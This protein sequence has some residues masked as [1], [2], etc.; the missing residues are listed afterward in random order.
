MKSGIRRLLKSAAAAATTFL[1]VTNW[2][3]QKGFADPVPGGTLDPLTVPKYQTPLVIPPAMPR[4]DTIRQDR[5]DVDYYEIAVRQFQQQVLP[6]GMPKTTVWGYGNAA[7]RLPGP[8]VRTSFNYPG[9]TIEA[10]VD[11][12]VRV[13]WINKL[14]DSRNNYLA[15]LLPLDQTLMW[16]NP[17]GGLEE[18]DMN[19]TDPTPYTGPVPIVTHLHGAHSPQESDGFP[20][21][22]FL[23][24]AKNIPAG[25]AKTGTYYDIF[26]G[27]SPLGGSWSPGSALFQYPN[28]QRATTLWY[29]DHTLGMSRANVYT[30]LAGFYIL[31]GGSDDRII[32][33]ATG[34]SAKLPGPAPAL[35]DSPCM[36]Y[37]EIPLAIQDH[38]FNSDGSLFYP[39][40]RD[41]FEN[42]PEGTLAGFGV[43]FAPDT[44]VAPIWNP[45]FFGNTL[46][47]N[48]H[49]WPYLN[50]EP[51]RYRFRLLNASDTRFLI[52]QFGEPNLSFWQIG[53]DGGFLAEPVQRTD[54]LLGPAERADVIVDFT[55]MAVGTSII[56]QN[57]GPD[58]PFGGGEPGADFEPS[59]ASTT[60]QV[61][62]FNV[63]PLR[64]SDRST[65]PSRLVLPAISPVVPDSTRLVSLNEMESEV[66]NVCFDD[67]TEEIVGVPPCGAGT[68]EAPFGPTM[69][70]LGTVN[71]DGSG[72]PLHFSDDVTENPA[73]G[74]SE[75]WEIHNFT[76]D[77]HPIHV[78]LVQFQI[79][80]REV[81]SEV[82][83][84]YDPE[85]PNIGEVY[86]PGPEEDGFKDTV[87]AYPG[88]IT[89]LNATFDMAGLYVWHCH[90][91]SHEDNDMMRPYRVGP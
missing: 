16:A 87:V 86:L 66:Q 4:T 32:D 49:T 24:A 68:T 83:P 1:V 53:A 78:H 12:P 46:V 57:I 48:G 61:M 11:K 19:G 73:V 56:L 43:Q 13:K 88:E 2:N 23:P 27:S 39:D 69:A 31:R 26:K 14:V 82:S 72:N 41:F 63:V 58:E 64:S 42:L 15:H 52:L 71:P 47:V 36:T 22:W 51:R 29:H 7:D 74:A 35:G 40:N 25:Y 77:A 54:I 44:D 76:E 34:R 10:R 62:K 59:D 18:R 37:Y 55:N 60:G 84:N 91:L 80:N 28:D 85:N 20:T 79:V 65:P 8:G 90:I 38:S 3:L 21:A 30:G 75:Q 50:V 33:S 45:E 70:M 17:P 81:A 6:P 5:K 89:R 67:V 9:D